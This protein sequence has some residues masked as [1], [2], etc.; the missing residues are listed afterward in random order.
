MTHLSA[1]SRPRSCSAHKLT[2]IVAAV[3]FLN[4]AWWPL[5]YAR[6]ISGSLTIVAGRVGRLLRLLMRSGSA[7][8]VCLTCWESDGVHATAITEM[9]I[10]NSATKVAYNGLVCSRCLLLDRITRVTCRTFRR[11]APD[12]D[13]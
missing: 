5:P 4:E 6:T 11:I 13:R 3:M 10:V 2:K 7:M 12:D 1:I 9:E 8:M